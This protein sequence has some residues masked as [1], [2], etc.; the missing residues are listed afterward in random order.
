M[1]KPAAV[2]FVVLIAVIG[3]LWSSANAGCTPDQRLALLKFYPVDKVGQLCGDPGSAPQG[4]PQQQTY[5]PGFMPPLPFATVCVT[6]NGT[7]PM[8]VQI[9]PGNA[10]TCYF[11]FGP[12]FGVTR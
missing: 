9:Y 11:S 1:R 2:L 4:P 3:G 5:N 12:A 6:A 7:C 8:A 10:C